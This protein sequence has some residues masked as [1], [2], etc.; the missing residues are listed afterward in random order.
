MRRRVVD[1]DGG[2]ERSGGVGAHGGAGDRPEERCRFVGFGVVCVGFDVA[3]G[4]A[5]AFDVEWVREDDGDV[6]PAGE[7][8]G[9]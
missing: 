5:E 9:A 3:E 4:V 6:V 8:A 2:G 7:V 1:G